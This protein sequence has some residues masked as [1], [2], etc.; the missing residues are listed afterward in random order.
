[1]IRKMTVAPA[2]GAN[3]TTTIKE[4]AIMRKLIIALTALVVVLG[5]T[6]VASAA[7]QPIPGT[8]TATSKAFVSGFAAKNIS[9]VVV[10]DTRMKLQKGGRKSCQRFKRFRNSST[11]VGGTYKGSRR[12]SYWD[13]NGLLCRDKNSPTGWVKRGGG[14]TGRD[15]RNVAAPPKVKMPYPMVK[16]VVDISA[17]IKVKVSAKVNVQVRLWCG[18][19]G[20]SGRVQDTI[21]VRAREFVQARGATAQ[22]R[23]FTKFLVKASDKL[24]GDVKLTC[25]YTPPPPSPTPPPTPSPSCPPGAPLP[26]PQCYP[27]PPPKQPPSITIT[28][29]PHLMAPNS[30]GKGAENGYVYMETADPDGDVQN[31]DVEVVSGGQ[32]ANWT[33]LIQTD[34]CWR[35]TLWALAPGDFVF[36]GVVSAGGDVVK[37]QNQTVKVMPFEF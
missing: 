16:S 32:Y 28:S 7:E 11:V 21:R 17:L 34:Q 35:F 31:A 30:E 25:S 6:T 5:F 22:I 10:Q 33:S 18:W 27:T 24:K 23:L 2:F 29:I 1:M 20:A 36:R 14:A 26:Y 13:T 3:L 15:C 9:G 19:S 4:K 37:S 12:V 8:V